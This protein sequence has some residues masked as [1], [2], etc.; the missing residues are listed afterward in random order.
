MSIIILFIKFLIQ[1]TEIHGPADDAVSV[2]EPPSVPVVTEHVEAALDA[3]ESSEEVQHIE[4]S[5]DEKDKD[6]TYSTV[7]SET[8]DKVKPAI[9]EESTPDHSDQADIL[10]GLEHGHVPV[11]GDSPSS[12]VGLVGG[13]E[14]TL[15]TP[16]QNEEAET[17]ASTLGDEVKEETKPEGAEFNEESE[18]K[19]TELKEET[20]IK[21]ETEP[22]VTSDASA[23]EEQSVAVHNIVPVPER[24]E[25][26]EFTPVIPGLCFRLRNQTYTKYHFYRSISSC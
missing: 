2:A 7:I 25:L 19:E 10:S 14:D 24:E 22:P 20:E 5:T 26:V 17:A 1:G 13:V 3:Q 18:V 12:A 8:L 11:E 4:T 23:I 6:T 16:E 15:P 9:E 21:E